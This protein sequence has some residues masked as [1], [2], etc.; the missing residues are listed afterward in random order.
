MA[1]GAIRFS[2]GELGVSALT[3]GPPDGPLALCLHGYP[4]TPHT[5]RRVAP[6]LAE[7]GWRVVAPFLR[8]YHPT[9][10]APDGS[11]E[12]GA[13]A[14]DA[15]AAHDALGGDERAVLI[16]HDW[17]ATATYCAAAARPGVFARVV[18][19]AVPPGP[20]ILAALR[21]DP[22]LALRQLRASWYMLF[23]QLPA[24]SEA[25]LE[26][27]IPRLWADWSPG[28]DATEDLVHVWEALPDRAHRTAALRFY[29]ALLAPGARSP[30]YAG[31]TRHALSLP[32][33][34]LLYLYGE[35]DGCLRPEVSAHAGRVLGAGGRVER[36]EGAGHFLQLEQPELVARHIVEFLTA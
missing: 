28:Y 9:D 20:A 31:L 12:I 4:D 27:L 35:D 25:A 22:V 36:I 30:R 24:V 11:Y 6:T 15:L 17:G 33:C 13:L 8:G 23:Q 34:P 19:L 10:L 1:A 2:L 21:G 32:A 29:R 5:W 3:W 7:H 16:G 26:R 18:T 14:S